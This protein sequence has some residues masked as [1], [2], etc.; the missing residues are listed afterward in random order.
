MNN[1][2]NNDDTI[3]NDEFKWSNL[4]NLNSEVACP[5]LFRLVCRDFLVGTTPSHSLTSKS[6]L[7]PF[8]LCVCTYCEVD[9]LSLS[10][11]T[12]C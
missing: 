8:Q 11:N 2:N 7:K 5:P 4:L 9:C 12:V 10:W 1:N 6:F 3:T